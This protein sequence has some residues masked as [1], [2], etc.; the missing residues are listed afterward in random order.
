[1]VAEIGRSAVQRRDV[2]QR[3]TVEGACSCYVDPH[4]RLQLR[5]TWRS[6]SGYFVL[7]SSVTPVGKYP[8]GNAFFCGL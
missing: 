5:E 1:M 8:N 3:W 7:F 4:S 6:G 2:Q